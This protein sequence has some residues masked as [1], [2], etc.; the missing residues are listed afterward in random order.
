MCEHAEN[1]EG[2]ANVGWYLC[3]LLST[4]LKKKSEYTSLVIWWLK[5][6]PC[7][8]GNAGSIPGQG[9]KIPHVVGQLNPHAAT[10]TPHSQ[11]SK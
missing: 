2:L 10:K 8:A 1:S 7:N 11:I 9:T 4:H 3:V 6:P 5:N